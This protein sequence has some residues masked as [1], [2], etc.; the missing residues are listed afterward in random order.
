[1][2]LLTP[3]WAVMPS[4]PPPAAWVLLIHLQV[5]P[6]IASA[7]L[8][9]P[10]LWVHQ[11]VPPFALL[12]L[13]AWLVPTWDSLKPVVLFPT[14]HRDATQ[15]RPFS[16]QGEASCLL[17]SQLQLF[18]SSLLALVA[19]MPSDLLRVSNALEPQL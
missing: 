14:T 15:L 5:M 3:P 13:L 16:S 6:V 10:P 2:V 12:E 4:V 7:P 8:E 1:M 17:S 19:Q 11:H 18:L 9:P